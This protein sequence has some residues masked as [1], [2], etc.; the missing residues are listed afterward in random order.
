MKTYFVEVPK[1]DGRMKDW[2]TVIEIVKVQTDD[3]A[4]REEIERAAKRHVK[5]VK[6]GPVHIYEA[7]R[8]A[9]FE[10]KREAVS[11]AEILLT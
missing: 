11:M 6:E 7:K 8:M 5:R 1:T 9:D 3:D 4:T 10:T 2:V